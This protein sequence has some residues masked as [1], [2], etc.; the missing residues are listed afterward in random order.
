MSLGKLIRTALF[1]AVAAT[2]PPGEAAGSFSFL[3]APAHPGNARNSE[4]AMVRL[5]NGRLLLAWTDFY[6]NDSRDGAPARI[7]AM[8][9]E[10]GGKSWNHRRVLQANIGKLNV[11]DVNL[12]RLHSGNVLFIFGR[13]NSAADLLPMVRISTDDAKT[14]SPPRPMRVVPYPSF[15]G[16]NNDRAVQ[17]RSGRILFPVYFVKDLR[18]DRHILS[19]VYFSDDEGK[20]WKPSRQTIDVKASRAGAQEPG[21]VELND[22]RLMLWVRTSTGHPYQCYSS[23]AGETWSEPKPMN[24]ASPLSPQSIKRIPGTADL[25]MVWNNSRT[26]RF[27]LTTAIS[28]DGGR[29]WRHIK[30]L[31]TDPAHTYGYTSITFDGNRVLFTYYSGPPA[32][33]TVK[34]F[35]LSLKLKSVSISW[36]YQ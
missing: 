27:P 35:L 32:G 22:G 15:T 11:M 34:Q 30:N 1:P 17:L 7:T 20:S 13:K 4:A 28:S 33:V 16:F 29:S 5:R 31:D 21:V 12:L 36:L 6:T 3:V 18:V 19:R 23:D 14:F 26:E 24:V 8:T 9:S 25:L 2:P 10:D